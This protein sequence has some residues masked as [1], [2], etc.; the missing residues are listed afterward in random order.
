MTKRT[1]AFACLFVILW[2]IGLAFVQHMRADN[3]NNASSEE[4]NRLVDDY[5]DAQ[6]QF[7][8]KE[9][10]AA[11]FHQYDTKLEDYSGAAREAEAAKLRAL[12]SKL[13]QISPAELSA[14]SAGDLAF[15]KSSLKARLLELETLQ[16]WRKDPNLYTSGVSESIFLIVKRNFAAPEER[17]RSVIARERQVPEALM[18]ARRNLQDT[19]KIYTQIALEQMPGII[20]FFRD[21]VPAA[22][23]EVKD[24][25]LRTEFHRSNAA[26]VGALEKYQL[27][28]RDDLLPRSHGDFRIGADNFR[29]KLLDEEMV[30]TPLDQLLQLGYAD[31]HHNQQRLKETAALI[32]PHASPRD[33]LAVLEKDHP[34]PDKLLETF[35]DLL[36]SLRQFIEANKIIT[37]PSQ[38][39][40][41]LEETPPFMRATTTASMDTPGPYEMKATEAMFNVT[42]P[43]PNWTPQ[44]VEDWMESF[45]RGTIVSTAVHEAYPGHY[46]QFLWIKRI[47]SKVR[48]LLYCGTNV[49]GWAHYTEQM[50][51]DEG[52]GGGDPKLRMGQLQ[53]A[54]LRDARFI[55][56]IEMHT[57]R[58]NL[59]QAKEFFVREGYQVP[60]VADIEAKRGTVDPTYLVYTLGK[61]QILKLREDYKKKLGAAFTLQDFHD[62]LMEQGGVPLPIIRKAMLGE[63]GDRVPQ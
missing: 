27:F 30:D 53:D 36:G 48:K 7:H 11:G 50:M 23:K 10:T 38:I 44:H 45:N 61:L 18:T 52:F 22:F 2:C 63:S 13:D 40:P 47:H 6:F 25:T 37:I 8:P 28:L 51:L 35:R 46:T 58:M 49:E 59:D 1:V 19:P 4:F 31:L 26:V 32:D 5:F 14:E 3:P 54:L 62:R 55:V 24:G 42:L 12:A 17:Q 16:M 15:L 60:A 29:Q 41:I 20:A 33:V 57:G 9:A 39:L 34:A 21:D 56:G 43:E